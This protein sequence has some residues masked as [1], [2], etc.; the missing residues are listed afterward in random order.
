[1]I[2]QIEEIIYLNDLCDRY[3]IDTMSAGNLV[4]LAIEAARRGRIPDAIDY[5]QPDQVADMLMKIIRREGTGAILAE[6]IRHAAKQLDLE[7]LAVHVAWNPPD[8]IH[9]CSREW[10]WAMRSAIAVHAICAARS[11]RLNFPV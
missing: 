5:G 9:E 8:M 11:T 4:G 6:G 3:G 1:M 7:D 10:R 2:N